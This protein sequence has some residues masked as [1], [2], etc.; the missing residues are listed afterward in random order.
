MDF[1]T[2]QNKAIDISN[3]N[4]LVSAGAGSGK[5]TVLT[6][7]LIKKIK[8]KGDIRNFL[9]VT[10][11]KAAASDI[12]RKLYD[13]LLKAFAE[14]PNDK[15]LFV[16]SHLISEANICTISAYCLSL[17]KENFSLLG[18][19][20]KVRVLDETESTM[21]LRNVTNQLITDGYNKEDE[22][23]LLLADNFTGDKND[24]PLEDCMIQL[25]KD[26]R[27]TI[28]YGDTLNNCACNLQK[29]SKIIKEKGFF[30]TEM[31]EYLQEKLETLYDELLSSASQLYDYA[32]QVAD[33][34]AYLVPL[35]KFYDSIENVR[36]S[37]SANY[38]NYCAVAKASLTTIKLSGK[39]CNADDRDYIGK[40]KEKIVKS[41][42]K[43]FNRYCC[44]DEQLI[45][46]SLEKS[47]RLV[48]ATRKFLLNLQSE[49]EKA[50]NE[51][52]ALDYTDFE[53][54]TLELLETTDENG[55]RVPTEL[56]LK[57][58]KSFD[59][60]L[61][62][63]YQDV[64]PLQDRIFTL[65]AGGSH[66]FMVGDV[67]Q[68]IYRFRN[69]YPDIF[70]GYKEKYPE[71]DENTADK[72]GKIFLRENFRCSQNIINYVNHLFKSVAEGT[73]Y[74]VEYDGEWL[75][76]ASTNPE[77]TRPVTIRVVEQE[78]GKSKEARQ[79]EAEYIA[80]EIKRLVTEETADDGKPLRYSDFAVMLSAMKGKSIEYEKAFRKAGI[81]YKTE[82]SENFLENPDIR[83]AIS[84]LKAIDDPTDDISLCSLMRSP[85]FNFSSNDL[86]LIRKKS[87]QMTYWNSVCKY[88][89]IKK[90]REKGR[91]FKF[92]KKYGEKSLFAR[93][94]NFVRKITYW[95]EESSGR[96]C[97]DF[98][99][100]FFV[101]SGMMHISTVSGA[102]ASLLLLYEYSR[103]Y[104]T[105][106]NHGL[107]GFL[108][109]ISELSKGNK[110]ISDA[111]RF[112]D[113]DAVSFITIHK[114]KGLEFKVC[115][116]A[117]VQRNFYGNNSRGKI[118]MVRGEGIYFH[119][120]DRIKLTD[121][122]PLC[123]IIAEDKEKDATYGE[124]LRKLYVALTRAKERL[125]ITG[126]VKE[127]WENIEYSKNNAV[128]WM[129]LILYVN[130]L[131]EQSFF[132]LKPLVISETEGGYIPS[133]PKK[134][135][136]PKEDMVDIIGFEY[137][138]KEAI[139][140]VAKI[141]VSELREG[142]LEDDEYNRAYLSVPKSRVSLKPA[143]A[144]T[145]QFNAA[146]IGTANHL[147]MQFAN[148][149]NAE[150][151]VEDE[152]YNLLSRKMIT[153]A[154]FDMLDF[155]SLNV[156]F[157][158][159]LYKKIKN[160]KKVYREKRFSVRDIIHENSEPILVQGVIDCFFENDDG[161]F[162]VVD[163]KTDRVKTFDELI[164]RHKFQLSY[165]KKAVEA[166]T[167]K[168]VSEC[169]LYSFQLGGEVD[170]SQ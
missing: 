133:A 121:Y 5:T 92:T 21:I 127:G 111:A 157:K 61:I 42:K 36:D 53:Q 161:T 51:I 124:E 46:E 15:H 82:T 98:L 144:Q 116:L 138:N 55:N 109:Y 33:D 93:T 155:E 62:D 96:P 11:M 63:E 34:D 65:L 143:F 32:S 70:I 4:L 84:S 168:K 60:I 85:I 123:N 130:S 135:I 169:I 167:G 59:E 52:S 170:V 30:A 114:S 80:S 56:C 163:Y 137:P 136:K 100:T 26:L 28:D 159:E 94:L 165:Y 158:S 76:H 58:Q 140:T 147:F 106:S 125:Y 131:G 112:G 134:T 166:M 141:S 24:T 105:A 1:T 2:T 69:A 50:K 126:A 18:I 23:F 64:N 110:E 91:R 29:E 57:K 119:L 17:V 68:S 146:E 154:Q 44:G 10:F 45:S 12:K 87:N 37:V 13:E 3:K 49:Y 54:K 8:N 89:E 99:K 14:N 71:A 74:F 41:Q 79:K 142:L 103:K 75:I 118:N 122:N 164:E 129:E 31:G 156:F 40:W 67:K 148:F 25:F 117:G 104:E 162:T 72:D 90:K 152:G 88:I 7:R 145:T 97:C 43:L 48:L 101:S 108:D 102:R 77:I 78:T 66:R 115:F 19:S 132:D 39:G 27:V 73:P 86:Y 128:S 9:V 38:V 107:S 151:S 120:N 16:Q 153:K 35:S 95:R 81:P 160:S 139:N 47:A 113:E 6:H 20:P 83:L 22:D 149:E 150:K